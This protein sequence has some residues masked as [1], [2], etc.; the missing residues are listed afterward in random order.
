MAISS[1]LALWEQ[2]IREEDKTPPPTSPPPLF[3]VIPG[4]FI[5]QLVRETEKEAKDLKRKKKAAAAVTAQETQEVPGQKDREPER[6]NNSVRRTPPDGSPAAGPTEELVPKEEDSI[7]PGRKDQQTGA[8]RSAVT[9]VSEEKP[10]PRRPVAISRGPGK[11]L[12]GSSVQ[13]AGKAR[14]GAEAEPSGPD[15]KAGP[16]S[17]QAHEPPA[18]D[19]TEEKGDGGLGSNSG[20]QRGGQGSVRPEEAP[21]AVDPGRGSTL[22]NKGGN[23]QTSGGKRAETKAGGTPGSGPQDRR[24][25][26]NQGQSQGMKGR[27]PEVS[28]GQESTG[29]EGQPHPAVAKGEEPR[30]ESEPGD[31]PL[32]SAGMR[33]EAQIRAEKGAEPQKGAEKGSK[34]QV[35]V[36]KWGQSCAKVG[37][38]D[39]PSAK[40]GG[41]TGPQAKSG[42]ET[43]SR[44]KTGGEAGPQAK[45]GVEAG[46][47]SETGGEAGSQAKI[48][49][50]TEFGWRNGSQKDLESESRGQTRRPGW[51]EPSHGMSTGGEA[52]SKEADGNEPQTTAAGGPEPQTDKES[53]GEP[54]TVLEQEDG[55]QGRD[56]DSD[57]ESEDRWYETEKVWLVQ[58]D[59]FVLATVTKPDVGTPEL[60]AGRVRLRLEADD[61]ITEVDEEN[62]QRANPAEYDLA[63][64]LAAL[65]SLNESSVLNT[66]RHRYGARLTHTFAGPDLIAL[67]PGGAGDPDA[68]KVPRGRRAGLPPPHVCSLAQ[69]A[70]WAM[71][72]QR[73]DQAIVPLGRSGSG[74]TATCQQALEH[75]VGFAGSVDGRLSAEKIRAMFTVL[76]AFG[77]VSG[78]HPGG[79][80]RF[81]MIASLDFGASGRV[82][83]AHLQ[84]LLLESV[85]VAQQPEGESNFL[86]FSQMLAGLDLDLRTELFLHQM[87]ESNAFGMGF[88]T[89]AEEKQKAAAAF[90]QLQAAMATLG[91]LASEQKAI[92]RVLAAIYHLG[93]AGACKVGRKQFMRFEWA[94]QAAAVLGCD[95][96]ELSGA[97]FKHHLRH[98]IE[99]VTSGRGRGPRPEQ[100]PPT[101]GPK[102]TGVEC[103]EGIASGLYEEL[104]GVIVSLINRS[105]TSDHLAVASISVVDTA[106]FQNPRHQKKERAA[107]FEELCHNYVHERLRALFYERTFV[108]TLDRFKEEN[109]KVHFELPEECPAPTVAAVDRNA[110]Q[111]RVPVGAA[112]EE[113]R[114]LFWLLDEEA[115]VEGSSE[116]VVLDRLCAAFGQKGPDSA[117]EAAVRRCEQAG[118]M[119]LNH[120]LGRDPVRYDLSGWLRKARPNLSA[121]NAGRLLQQSHREEV[122]SLFLPR[123][124]LPVPCRSLSGLDVRSA[125]ALRR[126]GCVRKTFAS[127]FAAVRGRSVCAQIKLQADALVSVIRRAQ[128]H[129]VHRLVPRA[130]V[131]GPEGR[132]P[133]PSEAAAGPGDLLVD[134]PVLRAQLAGAQVLDALRLHRTGYP[135]HM[136]FPQF[137][138][139]FQVL[140]PL[141][142]KNLPSASEGIDEGKAVREL[143]EALD[144]EKRSVRVGRSQ[145]F[146]KA[147]VRARLEKEREKL[148]SQSVVPFQ[149]A[150][151]GFLSRQKFKR[152]KMERLAALCIQKNLRAYEAIED[153]PWWRL[154]AAVRPLLST[155]LEAHQLRAKEE[156]L[157][158][159]RRKLDK[160]EK[161][162][163]ELRQNADQLGSK[164]ADLTME[165]SDERSKGDV[166]SRVLEGAR[167]EGLR[168]SREIRELKSK[169]EQVQKNLGMVEK[170]LE[171]AQKKIELCES[172]KSNS[173]GDDGWQTRFDCAQ[174]EIEFLRKRVLQCEERL[175]SELNSR[176]ELD[177]KLGEAQSALEGAKKA[178]QQLKRKC[179]H[180]TCDL[181]DARVLL[182]SQQS[183]N[184]E[185]EKRQKR[186]DMQLAQALGESRFEKSLREKVTQENTSIRWEFSKLQQ[187]FEQKEEEASALKQRVALLGSR[188][189]ELSAPQMPHGTDVAALKKQLW[190][191]EANAAEQERTLRRQENTIQQLEQLRHRFELEIERMKQMH[192]KEEEDK[193][194]ELE[195]VRQ[196]C[197]KRLRQLEMQLEQEYEEKQMSL[198]EKQDL[199]GLIATLCEQIG[200][201]DFDVEKRL[202]RDLKRTHA[203]LAD[204]QLLLGSLGEAGNTGAKDELEKARAQ[205][206]D[207]EARCVEAQKMQKTM[208]AELE[209]LH[210]ELEGITRNKILVEE[211]LYQL[212]HE[213][214]D[215]LRRLDEDQEDLND[216]LTKHKNLIAQSAADIAQI[217]ELQQQ[218]EEAK[219]EKQSLR[220]KLRATEGRLDFLERSTVERGIVSRQEAVI[221]DLENKLDFQSVQI[222]RLEV[223]VFRL[224]GSVLKMGE[225]LEKAVEAESRERE[226]SR[227]YQRRLEEL[228]AE[229]DALAER[230]LGAGR[231]RVELEKHVE[232]LSAVR[233]T[234]QADLETAIRRIADLQLALE[235]VES[236]DDS[237]AESV[238]TTLESTCSPR[239]RAGGSPAGSATSSRPGASGGSWLSASLGRSSP[240]RTSGAGS[241]FGLSVLG[242][243]LNRES[244]DQDPSPVASPVG[245]SRG[246]PGE[247]WGDGDFDRL[248]LSSLRTARRDLGKPADGEGPGGRRRPV[249]GGG[250]LSP[251]ARRGSPAPPSEARLPSPSQALSEFVEELRRKRR[252]EKEQ[253]TLG[254]EDPSPLPIYQTTGASALRRYRSARES[255]LLSSPTLGERPRPAPGLVRSTSLRCLA[256]DAVDAVSPGPGERRAG[257]GSCESIFGAG[258]RD[259]S[260]GREPGRAGSSEDAAV[261]VPGRAPLVF[262]NRQFSGL[263]DELGDDDPL[264]P[265]LPWL[266]YYPGTRV[267]FDDF[268]PAI[269]KPEAPGSERDGRGGRVPPPGILEGRAPGG[270]LDPG[271]EAVP[272]KNP[273]PDTE[274]GHLSDSS[275]SSGSVFSY[276]SADSVK[277]RPGSRGS[278]GI[279]SAGTDVPR[280]RQEA[281][282]SEAEGEEDGLGSI[283]KKYLGK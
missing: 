1:R 110:M 58:K 220:E 89:K 191:L 65:T 254:W 67:Q 90:T 109:I 283:M 264:T 11:C 50:E 253:G 195:D 216:I 116:S 56:D 275:S 62:V 69:G 261:P 185:L 158:A 232:E 122:R 34:S 70:Y 276:R 170:Q 6:K 15:R 230:E 197:Q 85:R 144:L 95:Y 2:K 162:R 245:P 199:E 251:P 88:W 243:R 252:W 270:R 86:V 57:Q 215:L 68:M 147:G 148:V 212:Q 142:V 177:Q 262:Q 208:A 271:V 164:I 151:K 112:A 37:K 125:Q 183:R 127:S 78:G 233:Q 198:H 10:P 219:Q 25:E 223:L 38:M 167:A 210:M 91:I 118:Q 187:K 161:A 272:K 172:E 141:F 111:W 115:Q 22:L 114:G 236:S 217:R 150:C 64:N 165:L 176:R 234:L 237:D 46:P 209:N 235:E 224:R 241:L 256:T 48:E 105:L 30:K 260:S 282:R 8:G 28:Q 190:D 174:M 26:G 181:E 21:G 186:F 43:G 29:R 14:S 154:L 205:L 207:S 221:C 140:A 119:E 131:A 268:L 137:R 192:Q 66:L 242:P 79:S 73:R 72:G 23:F 265:G 36:R 143:L 19:K 98:I 152:A 81:S 130:D 132:H 146:L 76:R 255:G 17:P 107:T 87:A 84:T 12:G 128:V 13:G 250:A 24:W 55:E 41:E 166:A 188:I 228:K 281:G 145:V 7:P 134:V 74:K 39:E 153:W 202:R 44:A 196:S 200:H 163:N 133:P 53:G 274:P 180:L 45:T 136:G 16:G 18:P 269:R 259:R 258:G 60:A 246:V 93:A 54:A 3:S 126:I 61:S 226:N 102:M 149:A 40:A 263:L 193:E 59:G 104:F 52:Q 204:A 124:Q 169:Y 97:V 182:E 247:N 100:E 27:D 121:Q 33:D 273:E 32:R 120:Q 106:G 4:G 239:R 222:K 5:R 129:F 77:S 280:E 49:K 189:Q 267:D 203:L 229:M 96:E 80:T 279:V 214:A 171:E 184:H 94:N 135:D 117:G 231:R 244:R 266:R 108:S 101:P 178:A 138:R 213:R 211:Q 257:F 168:A 99:Q 83:A 9:S 82:A 71:L 249:E 173:I 47:R 159:L 206:Q 139:Q 123:S 42:G 278:G 227:Y 51:E 35:Q 240:S 103:V 225:E 194:E 92:W 248:S 113:A 63:D 238:Q 179:R 31:R 201:R 175:E 156:E 160:S 218:L 157:E 277:S 20:L 75:L 155:A